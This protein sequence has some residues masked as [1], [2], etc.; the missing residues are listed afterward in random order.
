[1]NICKLKV[2]NYKSFLDSGYI[3]I[4]SKLFSLIGQNNTGKS[5]IMDAIQCVFP[6]SKKTITG[7]DFHKG[8]SCEINIE[9]WFSEAILMSKYEQRH[10]SG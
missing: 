6:S 4:D 1:M 10:W 8:E 7:F 3:D 2:K 9:L 5:T